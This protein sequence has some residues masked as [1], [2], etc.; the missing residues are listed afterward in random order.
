[1]ITECRRIQQDE[2][3]TTLTEFTKVYGI[4]PEKAKGLYDK[5]LRSLKDVENYYTRQLK[6]ERKDWI[7][8]M[9]HSLALRHDFEI[10]YVLLQS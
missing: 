9:L 8:G 7:E 4:G 1:M 3:I 2:W 6:I 5:G 10:K